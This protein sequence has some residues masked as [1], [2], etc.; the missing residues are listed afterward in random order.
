MAPKAA[1]GEQE[2]IDGDAQFKRSVDEDKWIRGALIG[3]W[4][5]SGALTRGIGRLCVKIQPNC[6]RQAQSLQTIR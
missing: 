1:H 3:L 2:Y 6:L 5:E 4:L